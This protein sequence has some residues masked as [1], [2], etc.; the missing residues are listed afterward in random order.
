MDS[1]LYSALERKV[2]VLASTT[3][4]LEEGS[5]LQQLWEATRPA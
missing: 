5:G 1:A 3:G 2:N 4:G